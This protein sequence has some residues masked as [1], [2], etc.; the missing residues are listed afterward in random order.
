MAD[1]SVVEKKL[2][3]RGYA[4]TVCETKEEAAAYLNG[5]IDG[6]SVAFGGS[7]TLDQLGLYDLLKAHNHTVWHWK[8][9]FGVLPEAMQ[10]DVYISSANAMAETGE[11]VN[12]DGNGN[13]VAGT[14]FGHKKLYLV[15]GA[16]KLAEN[17]EKAVWRARNVAGPIRAMQQCRKTPCVANNADR[18]YDCKSP[19]RI[20]RGMLILMGPTMNLPTEVVLV[21][22]ELGC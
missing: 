20:C 19:D 22:E 1:F 14:L 12:I 5:A 3:E 13:R 17:L 11:I 2:K 16:N 18:C 10:T 9:G 21:K 8:D 6:V 7:K 4:V 15:V